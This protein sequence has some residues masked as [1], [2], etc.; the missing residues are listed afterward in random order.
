MLFRIDVDNKLDLSRFRKHA[1]AYIGGMEELNYDIFLKDY[2]IVVRVNQVEG[3][4][5]Q[6]VTI[7]VFEKVRVQ[8]EIVKYMILVP[9]TDSRFQEVK[10]I[11]EMFEEG[12]TQSELESTNAE[13]TADKICQLIKVIH[14]I[15]NLKAFL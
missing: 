4:S 5:V 10:L 13:E 3:K 9:A 6:M 2:K 14:K 15:N 11:H 7:S 8:G 1:T 12:A